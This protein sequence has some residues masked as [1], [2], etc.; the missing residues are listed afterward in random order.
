MPNTDGEHN[1]SA[2]HT[3]FLRTEVDNLITVMDD[4]LNERQK[5]FDEI[6]NTMNK[7]LKKHELV[8]LFGQSEMQQIKK[9]QEFQFSLIRDEL[10][11]EARTDSGRMVTGGQ[12]NTI[13]TGARI[14]R[15]PPVHR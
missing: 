8:M 12:S 5:Y 9:Q 1:L 3:S 13:R 10:L 15:Q 14:F 2:E 4:R 11:S 7:K 6:N